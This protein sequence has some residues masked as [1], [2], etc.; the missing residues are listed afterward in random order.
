ML[1]NYT[2]AHQIITNIALASVGFIG[3]RFFHGF[4]RHN[5]VCNF[6]H[7]KEDKSETIAGWFE[8]C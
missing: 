1:N 8:N 4:K 3:Y 5:F 2:S 7:F 6:S